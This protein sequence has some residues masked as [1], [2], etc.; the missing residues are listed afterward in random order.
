MTLRTNRIAET[1]SMEPEARAER[2]SV[3]REASS[4]R[5]QSR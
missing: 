1:N 4:W 5:T 2:P 3:D